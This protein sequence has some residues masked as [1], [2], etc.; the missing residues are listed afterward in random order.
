MAYQMGNNQKDHYLKRGIYLLPNLFTVGSLFAGFFAI[1]SAL[2]GNYDNAAIAVF[3]AMIMDSFDGRVARLTHTETAFGAEF[4]SITD[5]VSFGV[6]PALIM[7]NW[8]LTP[9]GKF[10]W[11]AAFL[12]TVFTALR[13]ARFNV[14]LGKGGKRYFQGLP[15]PAA[16]AVVVGSVWVGL[17][18]GISSHFFSVLFALVIVMAGV[19]EVSNIRY[20]SFKDA[21]LKNHVSFVVILLVVLIIVLVSIDPSKVLFLIAVV[22]AVSGP[23]GTILG[24]RRRKK[25]RLAAK[26]RRVNQ[27][28]LP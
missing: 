12:Y 10:G 15:S 9:L 7:Y 26:T 4:D 6:A 11:L 22:Y 19:L 13:L 2:K 24:L 8:I 5:M 17:D 21:D 27:N 1:I 28:N 16:A 14:Q 23:I 20:R 18:L 3:I 25:A